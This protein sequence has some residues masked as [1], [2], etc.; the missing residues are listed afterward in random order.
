MESDGSNPRAPCSLPR[1]PLSRRRIQAKEDG[2]H[3]P[4]GSDI[5]LFTGIY[6]AVIALG[7]QEHTRGV[8]GKIHQPLVLQE[9]TQDWKQKQEKGLSGTYSALDGHVR[10][11][12]K[13]IKGIDWSFFQMKIDVLGHSERL[14]LPILPPVNEPTHTTGSLKPTLIPVASLSCYPAL[15]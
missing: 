5:D 9:K 2:Q 6:D 12:T 10:S 3:A 13:S 11:F 8:D 1:T 15:F 14:D 7:E 4:H